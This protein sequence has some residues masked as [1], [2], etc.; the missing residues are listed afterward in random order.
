MSRVCE[1]VELLVHFWLIYA[2]KCAN[3]IIY[4]TALQKLRGIGLRGRRHTLGDKEGNA[5]LP[6]VLDDTVSYAGH[7][8]NLRYPWFQNCSL[9]W[10]TNWKQKR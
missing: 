2:N 8:F 4:F 9:A 1:H 6:L 7:A 5:N 10:K 3:K